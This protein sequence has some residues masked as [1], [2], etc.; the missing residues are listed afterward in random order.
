MFCQEDAFPKDIDKLGVVA[1][2]FNGIFE[3]NDVF[4]V[5]T[6]NQQKI[7]SKKCL[8]HGVRRFGFYSG[9]RNF[10]QRFGVGAGFS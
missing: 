9:R 3:V 4:A 5:M 2:V 10:V 1:R 7:H 8:F 6:E